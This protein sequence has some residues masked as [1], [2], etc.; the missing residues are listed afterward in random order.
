MYSK[1]NTPLKCDFMLPALRVIVEYDGLQHFA[2]VKWKV[3]VTDEEAEANFLE[4]AKRDA[5][6]NDWAEANGYL[7]IRIRFDE[8]VGGVLRERLLPLLRNVGELNVKPE[9]SVPDLSG[10]PLWDFTR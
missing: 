2:P 5:F 3:S 9:K 10:L 7:M 8:D 6:K 1:K 4:I